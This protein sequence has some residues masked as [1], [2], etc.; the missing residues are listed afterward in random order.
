LCNPALILN[1]RES[2]E[3]TFRGINEQL[4]TITIT[5]RAGCV[6]T[7]T[8]LV[9]IVKKVEIYVP[10]AFTPNNDGK[11]DYLHPIL[12]GVAQIKVFRIFNR[13]GELLFDSKSE[14]PGW[15]GSFKG[16][17]QPPQTVVWMLECVGLDGMIY[18]KKGSSILLR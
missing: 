1:D 13:W 3:P 16:L 8:Q 2:F 4:Y 5:T 15:D 6:T 17:A 14:M 7:D 11:N 9:K 12:R 10:T 18:L